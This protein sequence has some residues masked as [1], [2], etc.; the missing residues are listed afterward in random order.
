MEDDYIWIPFSVVAC[1][2]EEYGTDKEL[3]TT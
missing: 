2:S 3:L 1:S